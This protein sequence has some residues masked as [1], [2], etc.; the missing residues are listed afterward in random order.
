MKYIRVFLI[1]QLFLFLLLNARIT[2]LAMNTGFSTE[3]LSVDEQNSFLSHF[4]ISMLIA[5]PQKNL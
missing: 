3:A 5:E 4:D 1:T 2:A